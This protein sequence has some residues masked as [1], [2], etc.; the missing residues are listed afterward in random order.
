LS[1]AL[2]E[3]RRS[4]ILNIF[5]TRSAPGPSSPAPRINLVLYHGVLAAR[6]KWRPRVVAYRP[7]DDPNALVDPTRAPRNRPWADLMRRSF[8][9]DVLACPCCG[10]RLR[11]IAT[12]LDPRVVRRILDH[13]GL[14]A[15]PV[16][17]EPARASPDPV[18][19]HF[20]F[21]A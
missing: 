12:I 20:G 3:P 5:A 9:L 2:A 16:Q 17:I 6:A 4:W 10:G 1:F 21:G 13:L 8:G 19:A 11:L 18:D 15:D 7:A 14:R